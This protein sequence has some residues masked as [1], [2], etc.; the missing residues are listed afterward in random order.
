M[1]GN[2]RDNS[3]QKKNGNGNGKN[4]NTVKIAA[5]AAIGVRFGLNVV[6][7]VQHFSNNDD[8]SNIQTPAYDGQ[9]DQDY[10]QGDY[11]AND[12]YVDPNN[13]NLDP[14]FYSND[15]DYDHSSGREYGQPYVKPEEEYNQVDEPGSD[16]QDFEQSEPHIIQAGAKRMSTLKT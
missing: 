7:A 6:V 1:S 15:G 10:I 4:S 13:G 16:G 3:G 5:V 8:G 14:D 9:D 11:P 2:A 12:R